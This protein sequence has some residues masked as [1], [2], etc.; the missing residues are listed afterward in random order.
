MTQTTLL[1]YHTLVEFAS[2]RWSVIVLGYP[3]TASDRGD[4]IETQ[5]AYASLMSGHPAVARVVK[6]REIKHNL[7]I[8]TTKDR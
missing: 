6:Q 3:V 8:A 5:A 2:F 4:D 1:V 7:Q